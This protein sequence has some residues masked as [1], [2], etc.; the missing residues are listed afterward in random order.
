MGVEI[1]RSA[2]IRD[3]VWPKKSLGQHFLH[4]DN[5]ARKIVRLFSP[6]PNQTVLEIGPGRGALTGHLAAGVGRLITVEID[7]RAAGDLRTRFR[8]NRVTVL[9]QDILDTDLTALARDAGSRL[10]VIGNIPYNITTPILFHV[11]EHRAAIEDATIMM[12][13]EVAR[14][15]VASPWTKEY[16]ILSVFFQL[17][18]E[19]RLLFDVPP[20]AFFPPPR[21][22]SSVLHIRLRAEPCYPVT[23]EP[24]FREMVRAVFGKRRKMLRHSLRGFLAQQGRILPDAFRLEQRPEELGVEE[25]VQLGNALSRISRQEQIP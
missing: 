19:P 2:H 5:I 3:G 8:D 16:G 18:A 4:D 17:Y 21:V 13:R 25:L 6:A 20:T 1:D 14:R 15:L 22:V 7:D 23:D 12:Q 10:R 24:F 9:H 11:L